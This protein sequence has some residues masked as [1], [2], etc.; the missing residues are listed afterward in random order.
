MAAEPSTTDS[1]SG[2][3]DAHVRDYSRFISL[4]KWGAVL[5]FITAILVMFLISE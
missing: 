2:D 1:H 3:I 5:C 4:F